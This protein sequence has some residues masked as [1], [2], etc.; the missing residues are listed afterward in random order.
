MTVG[1]PFRASS[2]SRIVRSKE[3]L[4][5]TTGTPS[6]IAPA[7]AVATSS[8]TSAGGRPWARAYSVVMPWIALAPSG[9]STPGSIS[10]VRVRERPVSPSRMTRAA[11]TMRS[12]L[13][14]TP[15]VSVSNPNSRPLVQVM[16]P[17]CQ[18]VP[19][20]S[21]RARRCGPTSLVG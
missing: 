5:A 8:R 3:A 10:Q 17:P 1:R 18:E 16:S 15:V 13:V 7:I 6:A 9:I 2:Y 19:T 14:S 12:V 11:V 21:R 4:K 20:S